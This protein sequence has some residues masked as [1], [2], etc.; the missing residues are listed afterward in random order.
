MIVI[1]RN[2][3]TVVLTGWRAWLVGAIALAV[4]WAVLAL[5]VTLVVGIGLTLGALMLLAIPAVI[6]VALIASAFN[7]RG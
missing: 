7:R 4:T 5:V 6:G 3:K 2:G 1:Q